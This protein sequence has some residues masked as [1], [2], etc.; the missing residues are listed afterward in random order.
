ML[1]GY[2]K[3][4]QTIYN[5]REYFERASAFLSQ[6]GTSAR[7]PIVLSDLMAVGR[8]LWKQG[9]LSNYKLEYWKFLAHTLQQHRQHFD[10]AITLAIMGHH[11]FELTAATAT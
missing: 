1:A 8:S 5:P 11:F 2:R 10:K 4:L 6:L 3:I 9:L 7:A